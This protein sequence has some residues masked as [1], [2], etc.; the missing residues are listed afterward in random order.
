[1]SIQPR[2]WIRARDLD[3]LS[4]SLER[5]RR[6]I[7]EVFGTD[8]PHPEQRRRLANLVSL[9]LIRCLEFSD[10]SNLPQALDVGRTLTRLNFPQPEVY[11]PLGILLAHHLTQLTEAEHDAAEREE[12]NGAGEDQPRTEVADAIL[13]TSNSTVAREAESADDGEQGGE[14]SGASD[15][16]VMRDPRSTNPTSP[17]GDI[18]IRVDITPGNMRFTLESTLEIASLGEGS[19]GTRED[20]SSTTDNVAE[21][22]ADA[23]TPTQPER[24][25]EGTIITP[26]PRP[27]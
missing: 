10:F 22:R 11:N 18:S 8:P 17:Q 7:P 1:M 21:D 24:S 23:G 5:L 12:D 4:A 13:A 14:S 19:S 2:Q 6:S 15:G 26:I 20:R 27:A 16:T 25:S 3:D 9:T